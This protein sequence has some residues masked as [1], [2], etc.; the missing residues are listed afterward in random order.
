MEM[1]WRGQ[2]R[3]SF[4]YRFTIAQDHK[5][6]IV[7]LTKDSMWCSLGN[8]NSIHYR[9]DSL[10]ITSLPITTVAGNGS[11]GYNGDGIPALNASLGWAISTCTDSKGNLYIADENNRI[12]KVETATGLI[13]TIAGDRGAGFSGDGGNVK[14]AQI[15]GPWD[16]NINAAGDI[17]FLDYYNKCVRKIS[18]ATGIITTIA[19]KQYTGGYPPFNGDGGAATEAKLF[20]PCSMAMDAAGNIYIS[21]NGFNRIRKVDASNG[22]ITTIAG[23]GTLGYS[24]DNGPAVDASIR[25]GWITVDRAGENLYL[26]DGHRVRKVSLTSGIITTIAGTG[27]I[28]YSGEGVPALEAKIC[29]IIGI[30]VDAGGNVYVGQGQYGQSMQLHRVLKISASD[31]KVYTYVGNG[32]SFMNPLGTY[33]GDGP[34]ATAYVVAYPRALHV[35]VLGNLYLADYSN[36]IRKI[37]K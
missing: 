35:D 15:N 32:G 6:K 21:D 19:G 20:N 9:L 37:S 23:N 17:V 28:G 31:K 25:A 36:R 27:T 26:G 33:P 34:H 12:R 11:R 13:S 29:F 16:L 5:L 14:D 18:V 7:K 3:I 1:D 4:S 8:T 10:P 24:G 30:A 22:I 2:Y